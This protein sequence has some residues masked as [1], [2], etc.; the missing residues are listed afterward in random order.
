MVRARETNSWVIGLGEKFKFIDFKQIPLA[1][2]QPN[3]HPLREHSSGWLR[4]FTKHLKRFGVVVEPLIVTRNGG[5]KYTIVAGMGRYLAAKRAGLKSLPAIVVEIDEKTGYVLSLIE[6]LIRNGLN[7]IDEARAY[8]QLMEW[9]WTQEQI[10][11]LIGKDQSY[12]SHRIG[13]LKLHPEVQQMVKEGYEVSKAE[14][15]CTVKNKELQLELARKS[16]NWNCNR[17]SEEVR[18]LQNGGVKQTPKPK[19]YEC[20]FK[21]AVDALVEAA[22]QRNLEGDCERCPIREK[23]PEVVNFVRRLFQW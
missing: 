23:C 4:R 10:G 3:P 18:K 7:P 13:L 19:P 16:V 1:D 17:L 12:V 21:K 5:R 6:N 11:Y 22:V 9:G 20:E 15:L 2:I 8:K 14:I